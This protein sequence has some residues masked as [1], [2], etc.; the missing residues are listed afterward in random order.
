MRYEVYDEDGKLFRKFWDKYSAEKFLQDGW[1]LV[2]RPK[3][4]IVKPTPETHGEA[5]W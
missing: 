4:K 1:S 2:V 3:Q 5:R